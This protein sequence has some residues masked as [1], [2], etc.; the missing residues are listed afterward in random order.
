MGISTSKIITGPK[1]VGD[2]LLGVC[3]LGIQD[4]GGLG[5][6]VEGVLNLEPRLKGDLLI[7]SP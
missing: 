7:G 2:N 6:E 1:K 4:K 3:P 5:G